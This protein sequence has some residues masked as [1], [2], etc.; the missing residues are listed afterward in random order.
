MARIARGRWGRHAK[1]SPPAV[2]H[3]EEHLLLELLLQQ[4]IL[5]LRLP[6]PT[7]AIPITQRLTRARMAKPCLISQGPPGHLE[8]GRE[9]DRAE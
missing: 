1:K 6:R 7:A 8:E 5:E 9:L 2:P 4:R 3:L